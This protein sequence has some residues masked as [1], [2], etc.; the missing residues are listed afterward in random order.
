MSEEL[1]AGGGKNAVKIQITMLMIISKLD[2]H[3]Y[4]FFQECGQLQLNHL[5]NQDE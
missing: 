3:R 5:A 1:G 4:C 2:I